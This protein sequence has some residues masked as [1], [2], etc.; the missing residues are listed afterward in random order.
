MRRYRAFDPPEYLDWTADPDL[1]T[2]FLER[3]QV[4][5]DRARVVSGLSTDDLLE[6]YRDLLRAQA[7]GPPGRDLQGLV[8]NR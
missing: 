3:I 7:L 1:V 5:T 4:D 6:L 8:G 2:D